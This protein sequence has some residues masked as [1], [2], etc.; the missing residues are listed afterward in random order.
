VKDEALLRRYLDSVQLKEEQRTGWQLRGIAE[1]ESVA[2]HSWGTA[3]LCLLFASLSGVDH[4]RAVEMAVVHDLA[5]ARTGDVAT[6][7]AEMDDP[8][9]RRAKRERESEAMDALLADVEGAV[10]RELWEEYEAAASETARFVRD[11]NMID[12]CTQAF[13]YERDRRYDE[14]STRDQF[15][16]WTRMEEFFATTEPRIGTATGRRLFEIVRGWYDSLPATGA[17]GGY[18]SPGDGATP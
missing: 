16:G 4:C 3:Y 12:M 15:E 2:D 7:V 1:P 13:R 14:E 5:E 11:M 6:R 9:V 8:D 10:V 18:Q 17:T